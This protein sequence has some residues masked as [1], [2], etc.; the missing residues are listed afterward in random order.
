MLQPYKKNK[1]TATA[2]L[3]LQSIIADHVDINEILGMASLDLSAAFNM[4]NIELLIKQQLKILGL[5]LGVVDLI[6]L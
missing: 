4:V 5:S 3:L 1:S 6:K 2:G